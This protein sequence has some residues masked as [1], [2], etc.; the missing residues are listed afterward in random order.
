M[1]QQA[2]ARIASTLQY[3][4]PPVELLQNRSDE[5]VWDSPVR[6]AVDV[7]IDAMVRR[8]SL[9]RR[10]EFYG[11]PELTTHAFTVPDGRTWNNLYKSILT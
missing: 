2:I 9:R 8:S 3:S 10:G 4:V 6:D 1:K 11:E 5:T 7:F